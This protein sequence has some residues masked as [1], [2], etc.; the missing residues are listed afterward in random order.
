VRSSTAFTRAHADL[1]YRRGDF[2]VAE[3]VSE[4]VLSLP[5]YPELTAAQVSEV[6]EAVA[7]AHAD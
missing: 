7:D 4:Q 3:A 2:P 1:G 6:A 5:V